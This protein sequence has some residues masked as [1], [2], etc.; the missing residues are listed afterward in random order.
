M[1]THS[2]VSPTLG[3]FGRGQLPSVFS[4]FASD[5]LGERSTPLRQSQSDQLVLEWDNG[6]TSDEQQPYP[7]RVRY[8]IEWRVTLNNQVVAKDTKQDLVL[9]PSSYWQEIKQKAE[10]VLRRKIAR[11]RRVR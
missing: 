6:G 4:P 9:K 1:G 2:F 5:I 10:N 3:Y 8:L 11:N 7:V